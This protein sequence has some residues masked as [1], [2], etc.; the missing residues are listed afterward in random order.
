MKFSRALIV[1]SASTAL[2]GLS[3]CTGGSSGTPD[4]NGPSET[5]APGKAL[6]SFDPCTFFQPD[7]LTS[8]GV[9]T[10]GKD[11]SP[12]PSEPGCEWEGE[13]QTISLQ[14]NVDQTVAS[15]ETGGAWDSYQKKTI[16]G[17]SAAI[18]LETG[19]TGQGSCTALVDA[20]G[21]V[22]IYM[23]DGAMRDS[24]A[25]PC[26]ETEKIVGQTASRLPQ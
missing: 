22:A 3:A 14:K 10:Q 5:Q 24:V 15:Y 25:D 13:K 18:A 9:S 20:G 12:I 21:G 7:E 16:G 26:A 23:L 6:A 2:I 4:G 8:Y 19:A 1:A 11:F 17:R